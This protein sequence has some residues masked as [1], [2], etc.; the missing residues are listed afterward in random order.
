[1]KD[2]IKQI[3]EASGYKKASTTVTQPSTQRVS[4][5]SNPVQKRASSDVFDKFGDESLF[6]KNSSKVEDLSKS[7]V[8]GKS[9]PN[10]FG[11]QPST[12]ASSSI[13]A[14]PTTQKIAPTT[15]KNPL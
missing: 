9:T 13:L 15:N 12:L 11:G 5:T 10:V 8:I 2:L 3:E 7:G 14:P 4:S 1:M 6:A